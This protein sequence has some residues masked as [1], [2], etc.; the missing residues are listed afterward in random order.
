VPKNVRLVR[1]LS[2]HFTGRHP[3]E[4]DSRETYGVLGTRIVRRKTIENLGRGRRSSI[5]PF[6]TCFTRDDFLKLSLAFRPCVGVGRVSDRRFKMTSAYLQTIDI[7]AKKCPLLRTAHS[8]KKLGM[9]RMAF[10]RLRPS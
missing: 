7:H 8:M 1:S 3:I 9:I 6:L 10:A 5:G 2:S 4:P